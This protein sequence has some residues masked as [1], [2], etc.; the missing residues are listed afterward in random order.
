M[1]E[2]LF[3]F[4]FHLLANY[5]KSHRGSLN[6]TTY[7]LYSWH[8]IHQRKY[9][10]VQM[11]EKLGKDSERLLLKVV[12]RQQDKHQLDRIKDA[13]SP[14]TSRTETQQ[15]SAIAC[16]MIPTPDLSVVHCL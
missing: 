10:P 8:Y 14:N 4:Q 1:K 16:C 11:A 13:S 12:L 9:S 3:A 5:W 6:R 7:H 15:M 2:T